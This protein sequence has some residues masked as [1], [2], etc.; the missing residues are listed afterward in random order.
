MFKTLQ[1]KPQVPGPGHY[2][3]SHSMN[4]QMKPSRQ[5]TIGLKFKK[6][7]N[8]VNRSPGPHEYTINMSQTHNTKP[9]YGIGGTQVQRP[10]IVTKSTLQSPNPTRYF[11]SDLIAEDLQSRFGQKHTRNNPPAWSFGKV[12]D[13]YSRNSSTNNSL[14]ES[15]SKKIRRG[16]I[17]TSQMR[18]E[19]MK[20]KTPGP[21]TYHIP[22]TMGQ[23]AHYYR[24]PAPMK[25]QNA[26]KGDLKKIDVQNVD[27]QKLLERQEMI[28]QVGK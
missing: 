16:K 27:T 8:N 18:S 21:Q 25:Q 6:S 15:K 28:D 23:I 11:V 19:I 13:E 17:V 20:Q 3:I 10:S 7:E 12:T 24:M 2:E 1:H 14:L 9:K 22:N 4:S 26:K 5:Y